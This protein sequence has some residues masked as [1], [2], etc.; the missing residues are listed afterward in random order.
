MPRLAASLADQALVSLGEA[1]TGIDGRNVGAGQ[2]DPARRRL[3]PVRTAPTLLTAT[4]KS[5]CSTAWTLMP[6][7]PRSRRAPH[8]V[9]PSS[10][11]G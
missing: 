3:T 5:T 8:A 11:P 10:D 4:D 6:A 2:G 7:Q 9:A 1:V